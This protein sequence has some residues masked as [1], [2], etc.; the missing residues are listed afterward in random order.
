MR[1]WTLMVIG[2]GMIMTARAQS[3]GYPT[4][5]AHSHND[6]EQMLP[7]YNAY[8]RHFGSIEADV[9]A[10]GDTLLVG[11]DQKDL[12]PERTLQQ[13]YIRPLIRQMKMHH[14]K[15]YADGQSLQLLIDLKSS[16]QEVLPLLEKLLRPY[17]YYFDRQ[18]NPHAVRLVISGNMPPPERLHQFD[19]RFTFDGRIGPDYPPEDLVRVE[20]VSD[21]VQR[22]VQWDANHPLEAAGFARLQQLVDSVHRQKKAIR[23]WGTPNTTEAYRSLLKLGVDYIGTDQL[24]L[25]ECLLSEKNN[26]PLHLNRGQIHERSN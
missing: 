23:F 3:E 12:R 7:F 15:A 25:L 16:Y 17:W 20:L 22:F 24:Q 19:P 9:W 21:Q 11:H 10:V 2:W 18:K 4:A 8:A 1:K 14:G 13:L 5:R 6:Y 26:L